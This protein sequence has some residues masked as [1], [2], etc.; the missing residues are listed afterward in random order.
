MRVKGG[1]V[2]RRRHKKILKMTQGQWGSRSVLFRR[3]NE[4]MMKSNWYAYRDRR[5]RRRDYR[6]LWIAR[7]NAGARNHGLTYSRFMYG[8]KQTDIILNRKVLADLAVRDD[9]V[10]GALVDMAKEGLLAPA[11]EPVEVVVRSA[12]GSPV[13]ADVAVAPMA[14]VATNEVEV[15]TDEPD[16]LRRIEGI[17]PKISSVLNAAGITTFAQLADTS[18]DELKRIMSDGEV[19]ISHPDSWPDQA[20]LAADGDWD[21]FTALQDRLQGGRIVD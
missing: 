7:I 10:F 17:G 14:E 3:A 21:A 1:T 6:K 13:A 8:L 15:A 19:R 16:D 2:T 9:A 11:K 5:R 4:A 12:K 18:V 20:R